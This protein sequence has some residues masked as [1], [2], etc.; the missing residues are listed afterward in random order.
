MRPSHSKLAGDVLYVPKA[1]LPIQV[2]CTKNSLCKG[3]GR[4]VWWRRRQSL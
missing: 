3:R 4:K 2:V 1:T